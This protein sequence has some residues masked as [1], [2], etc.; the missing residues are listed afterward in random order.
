[1]TT[2]LTLLTIGLPWLGAL[3]VWWIGD[4]HEKV[5]H[6]LAVAFALAVA[7]LAWKPPAVSSVVAWAADPLNE[8]D[9]G[10]W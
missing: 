5:Q 3:L 7:G 9:G 8:Y 6:W 4:R 1:M 2:T 10:T